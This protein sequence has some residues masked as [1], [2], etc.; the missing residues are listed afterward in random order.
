MLDQ[1]IRIAVSGTYS[2]GKTTTAEALSVATGIPRADALTARQIVV[3]LLPG[4]RFQELSAVELLMLGLRRFEERVQSEARQAGPCISDGS[5]LH[6]WIYGEARMLVGINPGAGLMHRAAKRVAGIPA[7]PFVKQYIG[8]FGEVAKHRAKRCYDVFTH[9]PVEFEMR[10]DGHRPV[11][12]EYRRVADRLLLEALDDL[13][14]PYHVVRGSVRERLQRIV[15]L[16][17]LKVEVP[18]DDAIAIAQERIA[19]SR[20]QVADRY[21][22]GLAAQPLRSRVRAAIH[23]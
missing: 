7:K 8:A 6:E 1:N 23:Y 16:L 11:S 20:D 4:K 10:S 21:I 9:L 19:R 17:D 5:V 13:D 2:S 15:D 3:T 18:L 12:E 14:I 22:A